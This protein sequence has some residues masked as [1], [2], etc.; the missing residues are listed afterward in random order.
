[1]I[2]Q[3]MKMYGEEF[4][5]AVAQPG[6]NML[7]IL[8]CDEFI[9]TPTVYELQPAPGGPKVKWPA[10][11]KSEMM[12]FKRHVPEKNVVM[13]FLLPV[14]YR[15]DASFGDLVIEMTKLGFFPTD[16]FKKPSRQQLTKRQC[17][18]LGC[19][20]CFLPY[21]AKKKTAPIEKTIEKKKC[22]A[23]SVTRKVLPL[24]KTQS[25]ATAS[26]KHLQVKRKV[27]PKPISHTTYFIDWRTGELTHRLVLERS[28]GFQHVDHSRWFSDFERILRPYEC[29]IFFLF[30]SEDGKHMVLVPFDEFS[31]ALHRNSVPFELK[32]PIKILMKDVTTLSRSHDNVAK[33]QYITSLYPG[34]LF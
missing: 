20:S 27:L 19:E 23:P 17:E 29:P 16:D 8:T 6:K 22:V 3:S 33:N 21:P 30:V 28:P 12:A 2:I 10:S 26:R 34:H 24:T 7:V 13:V 31:L 14:S 15:E 5:Q 1:M 18:I 32:D 25:L 11:Y 4:C 9:V